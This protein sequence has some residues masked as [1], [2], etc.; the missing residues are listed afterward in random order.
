MIGVE[1]MHISHALVRRIADIDEFRGLWRGLDDHTTALK[2]IGDVAQHHKAF[3]EI[4]EALH[5]KPLT[6]EMICMLHKVISGGAE[7]AGVLKREMATL[8][9]LRDGV[10]VGHLDT[11]APEDVVPLMKKLLAWVSGAL[12]DESIH[13][14][15][16]IGVF[17]GVFLQISPFAGRNTRVMRFVVMILLMKAGYGYAPYALLDPVMNDQAAE[18]VGALKHNQ[19][20]LEEGTPDWSVW[21]DQFMQILQGQKDVLYKRLYGEEA[22]V[23]VQNM[24]ALSIA[25]LEHIRAAGRMTMKEA[26]A[27]TRGRRSTIKLR[28]HELVEAGL[29]HRHGA[30][31]GVWYALA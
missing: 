18:I 1:N 30:G 17:S 25:L 28:L 27:A 13:P 2:L 19:A 29:I 11:A 10:P 26:I 4:L 20:S 15:I 9:F 24:P 7:S 3:H 12:G 6:L 23:S 5:D 22:A 16:I 14:L 31:R 21:L 8:P